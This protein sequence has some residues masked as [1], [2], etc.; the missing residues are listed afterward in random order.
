MG[1]APDCLKEPDGLHPDLSTLESLLHRASLAGLVAA[2]S[3]KVVSDR[4]QVGVALGNGP[5][6]DRKDTESCSRSPEAHRDQSP[7]TYH[8]LL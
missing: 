2:C 8:V 1:L 4:D 3:A 5:S 7:P 6:A